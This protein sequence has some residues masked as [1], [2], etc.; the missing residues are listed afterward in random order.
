MNKKGHL[1]DF[2]VSML[3]QAIEYRWGYDFK[4]YARASIKRRIET[5]MIRHRINHISEMIPR[6]LH[7]PGF[8]QDVVGDFSITVT[9]MFRDPQVWSVLRQKVFPVLRTWPYFKIW[10]AACATGE[11]AYSMAILLDEAGLLERSIIYATDFNDQALK[12]ARDGIYSLEAFRKASDNYLKAG[13]QHALS[14]Y[15]TAHDEYVRIIPRLR[16]AIVWS[17]HNLVLDRVFGEMNL[18]LC[19]NALIYFTQPLQNRVLE[20][21]SAS[22]VYGGFLCLGSKESLSFSSVNDCYEDLALKNRVY[23]RVPCDHLPPFDS[24]PSHSTAG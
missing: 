24:L 16:K 17:N 22:L 15:Y 9:E 12:T 5:S 13:G 23:R 21:F 4:D 8:F 3:L 19:R 7:E 2:E 11:E 1:E 18:I 6:V 10:H 20:L 14:R